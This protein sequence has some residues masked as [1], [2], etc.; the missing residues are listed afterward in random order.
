[1]TDFT[2][3]TYRSL[4]SALSLHKNHRIRHDVDARPAFSLR[5][6]QIEEEM[7]VHSTYYFR[8]K[9][10]V[11]YADTI[12]A[13]SALGHEVGYHYECLTTC[14]GDIQAAYDD[15]CRNLDTLRN[16]A[17][18]TSAC[19][20]GSPRSPWNSQDIWNQFDYHA[21][22][23]THESM[24]DT[25]FSTTLY[26]TDTGRRWDG[27]RV[28]VR[29]KVPQYQEEWNRNGL[30]FHT[31]DEI[32]HALNDLHHQIHQ[33]KLLVNTHPQRWIP[34]GLAWIEE[35]TLQKGKNIIKHIIVST[36]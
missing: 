20:H 23:I 30:S 6:A 25:D 12:R 19:A 5:M 29:D 13:I 1:M 11:S 15:F 22:G 3:N 36:R 7:G 4:L 28:S 18:V 31:T 2:L 16:I 17:P 10:F 14:R 32:I 8:S 9:H 34:F 35:A 26:L 21:T 24:L 27:F 33:K